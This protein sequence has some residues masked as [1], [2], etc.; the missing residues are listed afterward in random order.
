MAILLSR[1]CAYMLDNNQRIISS[2]LDMIAATD[3]DET[4]HMNMLATHLDKIG[5]IAEFL[6]ELKT[7]VRNN[8][9]RD[10]SEPDEPDEPWKWRIIVANMGYAFDCYDSL[11]DFLSWYCKPC[12]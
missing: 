11:H 6:Q 5:W 2:V 4:L 12:D 1:F 8:A 7:A 3:G 9:S 10:Y